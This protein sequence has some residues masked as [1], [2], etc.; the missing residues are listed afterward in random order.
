M[1][2]PPNAI[3]VRYVDPPTQG[4]ERTRKAKRRS[5]PW[6][7]IAWAMMNAPMNRKIVEDEN[8]PKTTSAVVSSA[9]GGGAALMRIANARPSTAVIGIGIASVT[10]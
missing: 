9:S 2:M 5:R 7:I 6:I 8:E 10:Q 4:I 1:P 3:T